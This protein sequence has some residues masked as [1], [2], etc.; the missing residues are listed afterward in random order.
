MWRLDVWLSS[1]GSILPLFA[2]LGEPL[3][4]QSS[5]GMFPEVM[6]TAVAWPSWL[7]GFAGTGR[8]STYLA[9]YI[10]HT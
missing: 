10:D 7:E 5:E 9:K 3:L 6:F 4:F 1:V 8:D 2:A